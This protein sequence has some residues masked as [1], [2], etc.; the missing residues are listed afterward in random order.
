MFLAFARF[1]VKFLGMHGRKG[2][3]GLARYR[4]VGDIP[5]KQKGGCGGSRGLSGDPQ[6][7]RTRQAVDLG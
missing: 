5:K 6:G 4:G 1:G 2:P 7:E 3:Q